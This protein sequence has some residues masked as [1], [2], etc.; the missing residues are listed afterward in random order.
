MKNFAILLIILL[1]LSTCEK[2]RFDNKNPKWLDEMIQEM[3][4][5][6]YYGGS[7]I[8]RYTWRNHYYYEVTIPVSSCLYCDIYNVD[9]ERIDWQENDLEDY[10]QNK[11]DRVLIWS[12]P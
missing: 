7:Y 4:N 11:T 5:N 1:I 9:G 12:Y 6:P 10:L 3:E 2:E 8:E